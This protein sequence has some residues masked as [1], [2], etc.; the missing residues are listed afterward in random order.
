MS[1]P[2][3][4]HLYRYHYPPPLAYYL[5][6]HRVD[7]I[8]PS[9]VSQ[10]LPTNSSLLRADGVS[11]GTSDA[12]P[13]FGGA[14][15]PTPP[16]PGNTGTSEV[17]EELVGHPPREGQTVISRV[18]PAKTRPP[19]HKKRRIGAISLK[20]DQFPSD[21]KSPVEAIILKSDQ[22][23]FHKKLPIGAII[24]TSDKQC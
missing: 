15:A 2:L 10:P 11:S 5:P 12:R 18:D 20:S 24:L 6:T 4:H 14:G 9:P 19:L 7:G 8:Q 16:T 13:S 3:L 21:K 23:P 1:P 22:S 17:I